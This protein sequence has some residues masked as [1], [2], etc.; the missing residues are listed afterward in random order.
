MKTSESLASAIP[1]MGEVLGFM[2]DWLGVPKKQE[3][4]KPKD[5]ERLRK[6]G[7]S[8]Q[9][10]WSI[11]HKVIVAILASFTDGKVADETIKKLFRQKLASAQKLGWLQ[12]PNGLWVPVQETEPL[13]DSLRW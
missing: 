13:P 5:L 6:G 3:H 9:K 4:Y 1:N 8:P 12:K 2:V 7:L 11:T 10:Y